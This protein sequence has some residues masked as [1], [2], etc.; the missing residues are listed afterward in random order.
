MDKFPYTRKQTKANEFIQWSSDLCH[1]LKLFH[2]LNIPAIPFIWLKQSYKHS[3]TRSHR[4]SKGGGW[5]L[6][7]PF[8]FLS[9]Y[10][11]RWW[12]Q[13]WH[14]RLYL[15]VVS[16]S[17]ANVSTEH[18]MNSDTSLIRGINKSNFTDILPF[19]VNS[20]FRSHQP[21][22]IWPADTL[23]MSLR[24]PAEFILSRK[25]KRLLPEVN[26]DICKSISLVWPA[27][28]IIYA[29]RETHT[30]IIVFVTACM[31]Y[32]YIS[33]DISSLIDIYFQISCTCIS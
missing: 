33:T 8:T 26:L 16:Q 11:S 27:K 6:G 2:N 22:T 13:T 31:I 29:K 14:T 28:L 17:E 7:S 25:K 20:Y 21:D 19:H 24:H 9:L 18:G 4:S 3:V 1:I 32:Y 12:R 5:R 10:I 15:T 23:N 30:L